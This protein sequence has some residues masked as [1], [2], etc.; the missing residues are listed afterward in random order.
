MEKLDDFIVIE[1]FE[2]WC[3]F[4][5]FVY[6]IWFYVFIDENAHPLSENDGLDG[7]FDNLFKTK[8]VP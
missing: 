2:V 8:D 5:H 1:E 3:D 6:N 7:H 4:N